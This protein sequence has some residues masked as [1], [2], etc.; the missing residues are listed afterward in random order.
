MKT[1]RLVLLLSLVLAASHAPVSAQLPRGVWL[2]VDAYPA[3]ASPSGDFA[4][5][6]L[7]AGDG[8]GF[9]AGGAVG[10]GPIGVYGEYQRMRFDCAQCGELDLDEEVRDAGWEAGL[11][12]RPGGVP[13]GLRPWIRGGISRHQLQFTG[14]G[15]SSASEPSTGFGVGAGIA[16]P[17]FGPLEV[18]GAVGYQSYRA[19]FQF[20]DEGFADRGADVSYYLYRV[21]LAVRL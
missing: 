12:L 20:Q 2:T 13:L 5:S 15:E 8:K 21:G 18:A 10:S 9:V 16:Y 19:E 11:I 6:G 17:V 14:L 3:L 1:R 4:E 7:R